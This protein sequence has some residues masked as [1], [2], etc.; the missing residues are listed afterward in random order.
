[1]TEVKFKETFETTTDLHTDLYNKL[2]ISSEIYI[3]FKT[4]LKDKTRCNYEGF[5]S[6]NWPRKVLEY[7]S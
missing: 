6:A 2:L 3:S 5:H 1:M 7:Y 4:T